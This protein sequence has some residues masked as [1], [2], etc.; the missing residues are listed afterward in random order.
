MAAISPWVGKPPLCSHFRRIGNS[1]STWKKES[2]IFYWN[3]LHW[4]FYQVLSGFS[5]HTSN[6]LFCLCFEIFGCC[7]NPLIYLPASA[8]GGVGVSWPEKQSDKKRDLPGQRAGVVHT[9][10]TSLYLYLYPVSWVMCVGRGKQWNV[11]HHLRGAL[12]TSPLYCSHFSKPKAWFWRGEAKDG[13]KMCPSVPLNPA[14]TSGLCIISPV[15]A[16]CPSG[17]TGAGGSQ[18]KY[19]HKTGLRF[20][21]GFQRGRQERPSYRAALRTQRFNVIFFFSTFFFFFPL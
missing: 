10:N 13:V 15:L 11:W 20:T 3:Q 21:F 1:S 14:L 2:F 19:I 7:F 9:V 17:W 18:R 12:A 6:A 5:F 8:W 4:T 16:P